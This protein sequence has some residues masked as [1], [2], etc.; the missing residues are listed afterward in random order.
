MTMFDLENDEISQVTGATALGSSIQLLSN[1]VP[2]FQNI[3]ALRP[4]GAIIGLIPAVGPI[5][6][7]GDQLI[8]NAT[9][10]LHSLG[11][12][13][14]GN[15]ARISLDQHIAEEEASGVFNPL[16]IFKYF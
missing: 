14:G 9:G 4:I 8:N 6:K 5:H 2:A 1:I 16:G 15:V 12:S 10:A 7:L 11:T 3:P 13:L